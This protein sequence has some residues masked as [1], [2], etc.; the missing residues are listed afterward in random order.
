M[1]QKLYEKTLARAFRL[2][3][4][5]PRS[6]AQLRE[7]LLEKEWAE[8]EVVERVI[9][10]LLELGYLNDEQFAASYAAS[11]LTTKTLGRTRLR[12]DLQ[13]KKVS[14]QAAEQALDEV[15]AERG[16]EE[17]IARAIAKR[18]RLKGKPQ[19][20]EE[21]KKLFDHL[22]RLGFSYDLVKRKVKEAGKVD[23]IEED[24]T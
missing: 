7:R 12:R 21:T 6:T 22:M 3:A 18:V 13:R 5:R 9:A 15:Y 20:R 24:S 8:A 4:A 17:L 19:T 11:R 1:E 23:E 10:R 2:L 14:S 16:E